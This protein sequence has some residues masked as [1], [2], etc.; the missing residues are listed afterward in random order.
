MV[1]NDRLP[2]LDY[3]RPVAASRNLAT[4][5]EK[6]LLILLD[7]SCSCR[8]S[9]YLRPRRAGKDLCVKDWLMSCRVLSRGVE[10][11]VMNEVFVYPVKMGATEVVDLYI[12]TPKNGIVREFYRQFGFL[13]FSRR[14]FNAV[15]LVCKGISTRTVAH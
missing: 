3:R 9:T 15:V 6:H 12:P 8:S 14:R 7:T 11:Y 2:D 13:Q 4:T 1:L 5:S 10:Q